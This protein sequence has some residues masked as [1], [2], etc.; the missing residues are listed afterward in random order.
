MTAGTASTI[1]APAAASRG[2][3]AEA[4]AVGW[5]LVAVAA[6]VF[7]MVAIGGM[8][9]LT[10]SGLSITEW[11]PIAGTLPPLSDAD[12]QALFA[13]YK[14]S[15]QFQK[16]FPDLTLA[17]FKEIFW[18][19]YIHRLWGRLIGVVFLVPLLWFWIRGRIPKG[20]GPALVGLFVLGGLQGAVGWLMVASGLV[21]RPAVSHYRLAIH[22]GLA[23]VIYAALLWTALGLFQPRGASALAGRDRGW[24]HLAYTLIALTILAG[25]LV[26][27]LRAGLIYNGFPLMGGALVPSDYW[28]PELG[29][30]NAF[31]NRAAVQFHH[32]VLATLT[33]LAAAYLW[34]RVRGAAV[35]VLAAVLLQYALGVAT[36]LMFGQTPPPMG[37]AVAI[38]TLHQAGA[39]VLVTAAVWFAHAARRVTASA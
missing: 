10:E 23:I 14:Q 21:D 7:V 33:L 30:L 38:G 22:L 26:A 12:W 39:M 18:L 1:G 36:I 5:W 15:P 3:R 34:W 31:E 2:G 25:A 20:Y 37:E 9:R 32:R 16:T 29:W 17:G 8:T 11:Q 35:W 6:M 28:V 27:G 19:E 4:R 13:K 24:V